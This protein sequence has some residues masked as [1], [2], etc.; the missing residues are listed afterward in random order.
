M[1]ESASPPPGERHLVLARVARDGIQLT[2]R[3]T[4]S[5][6]PWSM[7]AKSRRRHPAN[8]SQAEEKIAASPVDI[9]AND[10][11]NPAKSFH[12]A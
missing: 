7:P 5:Q 4:L 2:H 11:R 12:F 6:K 1:T 9:A 8:S 3:E 10:G